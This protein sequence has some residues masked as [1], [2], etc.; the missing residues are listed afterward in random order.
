MRFE[1][2]V[3]DRMDGLVAEYAENCAN[4]TKMANMSNGSNGS[5]TTVASSHQHYQVNK[6]CLTVN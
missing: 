3:A 2:V 1:K 5:K 4:C 6:T